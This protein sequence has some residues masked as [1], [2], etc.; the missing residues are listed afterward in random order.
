MT[1]IRKYALYFAFLIALL[2]T[3]GSLYMSEILLWEPCKLCWLQRIFMYPLVLLL[4]IGAY[5]EDYGIIKYVIPL[6]IIGGSIST[7]HYLEQKVPGLAAI[8]PCRVGIPCNYDYLDMY[9]WITIP[10]LAFTA[11]LLITILLFA[12]RKP[13]S[14]S[15]VEA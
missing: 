2:A 9:G 13:E 11:F 7:Y 3:S 5:R 14:Q 8:T 15:D 6:A 1:F 12:A 10:L 4:G